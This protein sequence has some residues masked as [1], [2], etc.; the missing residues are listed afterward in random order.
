M[1][2]HLN[3][4][5]IAKSIT[6][7]GYR[8]TEEMVKDYLDLKAENVELRHKCEKFKSKNQELRI[9]NAD[10]KQLIGALKQV[11]AL[12]Q[13][14]IESKNENIKLKDQIIEFK[15][16]IIELQDKFIEPSI[17]EKYQD[18]EKEHSKSCLGLE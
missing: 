9:E 7:V 13:Q 8:Q 6:E 4:S 1:K 16:R 5:H 12:Q 10:Q 2:N 15:D 18:E 17:E 3:Q 14:L 11:N